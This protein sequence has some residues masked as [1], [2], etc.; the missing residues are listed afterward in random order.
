MGKS[1]LGST[2]F[3]KTGKWFLNLRCSVSVA[4]EVNAWS[5]PNPRPLIVTHGGGTVRDLI[6]A[7]WIKHDHSRIK[8]N[9][10]LLYT[11][12]RLLTSTYIT[13]GHVTIKSHNAAVREQPVMSYGCGDVRGGLH[14]SDV[15]KISVRSAVDAD[16]WTL[17]TVGNHQ[18][19][20]EHETEVGTRE[21][22]ALRHSVGHFGGFGNQPVVRD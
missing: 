22:T 8:Y 18:H 16:P 12:V 3:I 5:F 1:R 21:E 13:R 14:T 17:S 6:E 19:D 9:E 7:G 20:R 4:G 15:E 11:V 2:P 10:V